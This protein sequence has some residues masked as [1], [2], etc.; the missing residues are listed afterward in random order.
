MEENT[1]FSVAWGEFARTLVYQDE[2]GKLTF[3][4]DFPENPDPDGVYLDFGSVKGDAL[5]YGRA[6]ERV[7]TFLIS[8]GRN[9]YD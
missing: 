3:T 6:F 1:S 9:V 2:D 8:Q 4:F 7:K 5:R